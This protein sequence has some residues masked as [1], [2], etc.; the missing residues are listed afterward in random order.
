M[1][2]DELSEEVLEGGLS[3]VHGE[4]RQ[5]WRHDRPEVSWHLILAPRLGL[6]SRPA[7]GH[8]TGHAACL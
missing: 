8:A 5:Q 3:S 1:A 2:G 4:C 6:L 7:V